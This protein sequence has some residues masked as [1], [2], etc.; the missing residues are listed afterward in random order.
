LLQKGERGKNALPFSFGGRG[1]RDYRLRR[2][3]RKK[4]GCLT[5][6]RWGKEKKGE[7]FNTFFEKRGQDIINPSCGAGGKGK[8][9][10]RAPSPSTK[11][12]KE[13]E[14]SYLVVGIRQRW[15]RRD[16]SE[17]KRERKEFS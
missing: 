8:K 6:I 3:E 4:K 15:A 12:K 17:E 7:I 2:G 11:K 5:V 16:I 13:G 10:G 1:F 14:L 9:K